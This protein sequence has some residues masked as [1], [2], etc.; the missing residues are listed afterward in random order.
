[1]VGQRNTARHS[2]CSRVEALN[3]PGPYQP[4]G[5]PARWRTGMHATL[6]TGVENDTGLTRWSPA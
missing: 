4:F 2:S 1:M 3:D 6:S 5:K